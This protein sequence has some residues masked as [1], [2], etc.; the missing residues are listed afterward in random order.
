M[1][2]ETHDPVP[3]YSLSELALEFNVSRDTVKRKLSQTG[4]QTDASGRW[5]LRDVAAAL[6]PECVT[7][8][9]AAAIAVDRALRPV[10]AAA[11]ELSRMKLLPTA[12]A[13]LDALLEAIERAG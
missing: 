5:R 4:A 9:L 1:K 13:K 6:H 7:P 3:T 12:R 2:N 10:R 11:A 8:G